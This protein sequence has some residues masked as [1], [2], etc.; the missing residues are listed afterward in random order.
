MKVFQAF[1]V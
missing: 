1:G